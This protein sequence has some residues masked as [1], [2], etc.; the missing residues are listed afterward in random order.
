MSL[1]ALLN[2]GQR[3]LR[4]FTMN[5]SHIILIFLSCV[6]QSILLII[7]WPAIPFFVNIG[8]NFLRCHQRDHLSRWRLRLRLIV[9][10]VWLAT[11]RCPC[12]I[13]LLITVVDECLVPDWLILLCELGESAW[14]LDRE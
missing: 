14:Y 8:R 5:H 6:A 11:E 10:N 4:I 2:L 3:L 9:I 1:L 12:I 13:E 7:L